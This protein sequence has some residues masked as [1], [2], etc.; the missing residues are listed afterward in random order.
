MRILCCLAAAVAALALGSPAEV[1][2]QGGEVPPPPP[3]YAPLPPTYAVVPDVRYFAGD[4]VGYQD[5]YLRLGLF[6]PVL[7]SY[8]ESTGFVDVRFLLS[9]RGELGGNAGLGYRHYLPR[10]DRTLGGYVY[11]DARDTAIGAYQQFTVG[12]ESLGTYLDTRLNAYLPVGV[13]SHFAPDIV[14]TG[15]PFFQGNAILINGNRTFEQALQGV[16]WRV[17]ANLQPLGVALRPFVGVYAFRDDDDRSFTGV[18]GGLQ[19]EPTDWAQLRVEVQSDREFGTNVIVAAA[20]SYPLGRR[21][22]DREEPVRRQRELPT[23]DQ[24][25][26]EPVDRFDW[27]VVGQQEIAGAFALSDPRNDVPWFAFH[28]SN[29]PADVTNPGAP[30]GTFENPFINFAQVRNNAV[31]EELVYVRGGGGSGGSVPYTFVLP[32]DGQAGAIFTMNGGQWMYGAGINQPLPTI[33]LGNVVLP[34]LQAG[35]PALTPVGIAGVDMRNRTVVSGITVTGGTNGIIASARNNLTIRDNTLTNQTS[36]AIDLANVADSIVITGNQITN[37]G[38][39]AVRIVQTD[40]SSTMAINRN[41]ITTVPSG[42]EAYQIDITGGTTTLGMADNVITGAGTGIRLRTFGDAA[43]DARFG[44]NTV[45]STANNVFPLQIDAQAGSQVNFEI[46][47]NRLTAGG[48]A[49]GSALSLITTGATAG[50]QLTGVIRDNPLITSGGRGNGITIN[51]QGQAA[52][53]MSILR[54]T[55]QGGTSGGND[56]AFP[57]LVDT[58]NSAALTLRVQDNALTVRGS[59]TLQSA[60]I[61]SANTSNIAALVQDNNFQRT[62]PAVANGRL[63]LLNNGTGSFSVDYLGAGPA[64]G[65]PVVAND[66]FLLGINQNLGTVTVTAGNVLYQ[67]GSTAGAP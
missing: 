53:S 63:D 35:N 44:N 50:N 64:A 45:T 38:S 6:A 3:T 5:G 66:A 30:Q 23:P 12:V 54:N 39:D 31:G 51:L 60:L 49:T 56:D 43:V 34:A 10:F 37:A 7:Q 16:D 36:R 61:R 32:N 42:D 20:L 41:T 46:F 2:G 27:I 57:L 8:E 19:V 40:I 25:L 26:G 52:G 15:T 62:S 4:G 9:N 59:A 29:N 21:G 47:G 33:E 22:R 58:S 28:V 1:R 17:N 55:I 13:R 67:P 14:A 11:F 48:G 18:R 24:R 65:T